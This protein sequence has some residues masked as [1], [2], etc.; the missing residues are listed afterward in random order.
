MCTAEEEY[1]D[2]PGTE[3]DEDMFDGSPSNDGS[4]KHP[5]S[6]NAD[7]QP[8]P[9]KKASS[10]STPKLK[11]FCRAWLEDDNFKHWLEEV[12][13]D[14]TKSKCSVCG[15]TILCGKSELLKH[16]LGA[17]HQQ[18]MKGIRGTSNI[19]KAFEKTNA[20]T[21]HTLAVKRA[22]LRIASFFAEHNVALNVSDHLID[23]LKVAF[24]DSKILQDV[25]LH[26]EKCK[27]VVTNVLAKTDKELLAEILKTV[28]FSVLV[29]ESTDVA[30]D[31]NMCVVCKFIHPT[32]GSL[33]TRLLELIQLD[34]KD[35]SAAKLYEAFKACLKKYDIPITNVVGL[36]CDNANV[37]V[38]VNDSFSSRLLADCPW[39]VRIA[40]LCHSAALAASYACKQLPS[41]LEKL[42]HD[43]ANYVSASAKRNAEFLEFQ[44]FFIQERLRLLKPAKT[45]W[46]VL[47]QCVVRTL[48]SWTSLEHLFL[49]A[50]HEDKSKTAQDINNE[51]KNPYTKAYFY[52]M[53]YVLEFFNRF[54]AMFQADR[55]KIH[56]LT[57]EC[58]ELLSNLC[59]N[60]MK[61]EVLCDLTSVDAK[62]EENW[63]S[64]K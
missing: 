24:P 23:M 39:L 62:K 18:R 52:F 33:Q 44:E 6:A 59:Q 53:K 41:T 36:G 54:N 20:K 1:I 45:R 19:S 2:D 42:L 35:C 11:T 12:P 26:R 63:V 31:K 10:S 28:P 30:V 3:N 49:L 21:A 48:K 47:Q 51:L 17:K 15:V 5:A 55:V 7:G 22:E 64:F 9:K 8:K 25:R 37:M 27:K 16:Q 13:E 56:Q 58:T 46:L 57:S 29:D 61:P 38:G 40:C 43:L 60:F 34:A 4:R 50:V 14:K 32:N